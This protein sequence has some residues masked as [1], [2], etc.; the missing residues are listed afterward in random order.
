MADDFK[1]RNWPLHVLLNN[2]GIQAPAG[3]RGQ[4]TPGGFEVGLDTGLQHVAYSTPLSQRVLFC[5]TV[6]AWCTTLREWMAWKEARRVLVCM[7]CHHLICQHSTVRS[8]AQA[9]TALD[10]FGHQHLLGRPVCC[11]LLFEVQEVQLH[12]TV[13]ASCTWPLQ[14]LPVA[15][16]AA[17]LHHTLRYVCPVHNS[18]HYG[19]MQGLPISRSCLPNAH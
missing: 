12:L 15:A 14:R 18:C 17:V 8:V 6:A 3:F 19:T 5:V 4:K 1:S 13:I 2:A 16:R 10:E 7:A 9:P 11:L